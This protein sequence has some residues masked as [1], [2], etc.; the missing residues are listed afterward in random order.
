MRLK[1]KASA[2]PANIACDEFLFLYNKQKLNG[3]KA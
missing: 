1:N 2:S 3:V